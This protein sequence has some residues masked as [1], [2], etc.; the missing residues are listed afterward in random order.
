LEKIS[1]IKIVDFYVKRFH[2]IGGYVYVFF[3][4]LKTPKTTY[5]SLGRIFIPGRFRVLGGFSFFVAMDWF[6]KISMVFSRCFWSKWIE[7]GIFG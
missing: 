1:A 3:F 5:L 2:I 6:N 7:N 4:T